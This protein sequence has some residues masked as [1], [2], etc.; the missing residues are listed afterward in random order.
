MRRPKVHL[1]GVH[2]AA[3]LYF[4]KMK[5]DTEIVDIIDSDCKIIGTK[6]KSEAHQKGLLHATVISEVIDSK[7]RFLL[8]SQAKD[9]QEPGKFVSPMGGHVS[10]GETFEDAVKREM[11]E[12]L[13]LI[14]PKFHYKGR[15]IYNVFV[16]NR[17]EN[18]YFIVYETFFNGKPKLGSESV[19]YRYFTVEELKKELKFNRSIFG[20]AYLAVVKNLYPDFLEV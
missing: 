15:F 17:Q 8:V 7:S 4:C 20:N 13:G 19:D 11:F 9:R 5:I 10:H 6:L 16:R 1:R 14:N 18:H 2:F 12:E 3:M